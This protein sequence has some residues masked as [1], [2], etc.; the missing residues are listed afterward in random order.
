MSDA[1]RKPIRSKYILARSSCG[2]W[3]P[4]DLLA[5]SNDRTDDIRIART[6]ADLTTEL[7]RD[8]LGVRRGY[9]EQDIA[10]HHEHAGRTEAALQ[11]VTGVEMPPQH[12]HDRVVFRALQR[13]HL[14]AIAHDRKAQAGPRGLAINIDCAR[15]AR[16]MLATQMRRR[17]PAS[18]AQEICK[19][20]EE[21]TSELQ[22]L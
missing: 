12:F 2:G 11:R 21:H 6:A 8:R 18:F 1:T 4:A 10:R 22:S 17:Q 14:A 15:T 5:G 20:S 13:L 19:R 16:T 9:A 7:L 3:A